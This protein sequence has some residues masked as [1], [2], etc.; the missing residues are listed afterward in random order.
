MKKNAQSILEYVVIL[1][2]VA[3]ALATMQ[4]YFRRSINAAIKLTADEIGS[5]GDAQEIDPQKGTKSRS[6]IE[7]FTSGP[8]QGKAF[9]RTI[10]S[11]DG[12]ISSEF[13]KTTSTTGSATYI[14][15][16]ARED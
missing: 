11:S 10:M 12:S 9:H 7:Q 6:R 1:G 4:I 13:N 15:E 2:V 8:Q 3:M 14:S 16:K 5:Q